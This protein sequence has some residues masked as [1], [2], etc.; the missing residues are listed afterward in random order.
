MTNAPEKKTPA[1][2][3]P[4]RAFLWLRGQDLNL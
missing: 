3:L 1:G 4:A 2:Y